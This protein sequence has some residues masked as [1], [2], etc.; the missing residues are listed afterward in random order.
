M[1]F[2][3]YWAM[4]I[5]VLGLGTN[6]GVHA[7]WFSRSSAASLAS[8]RQQMHEISDLL[9]ED[10]S[11]EVNQVCARL[12]DGDLKC[13]NLICLTGHLQEIINCIKAQRRAMK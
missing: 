2:K 3:K 8:L 9:L 12:K 1:N 4:V 10:S 11:A 5:L 13:T 6:Y 7:D